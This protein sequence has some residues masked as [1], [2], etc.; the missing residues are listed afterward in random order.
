MTW[1]VLQQK[2]ANLSIREKVLVLISAVVLIGFTAINFFI[3]PMFTQYSDLNREQ[4]SIQQQ[5][6]STKL[7]IQGINAKLAANPL[8][9]I[10]KQLVALNLQHNQHINALSE[11]QLSLI[12][13]DE[14]AH[15]VEEIVHENKNLSLISLTSSLPKVILSQGNEVDDKALLYR[16]A[17]AIRMEGEYFSLLNFMKKIEKK[18]QSVLWGEIDYRVGKYP[19]AIISFE[20]YTVSTDKEFIGVKK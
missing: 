4:V 20:I 11:Y 7:D 9:D 14:M 10:R 12:S 18:E 17:I 6:N 2:H 16:H 15:L 8:D 13:S 3:E 19:A 1:E 5:I